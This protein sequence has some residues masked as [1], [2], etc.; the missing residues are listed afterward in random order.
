MPCLL[1]KMLDL[2]NINNSKKIARALWT[3][4]VDL[5]A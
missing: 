1:P 4:K 3:P 2:Q 5:V